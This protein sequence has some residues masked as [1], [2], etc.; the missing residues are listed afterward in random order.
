MAK[1]QY[2]AIFHFDKECGYWVEFPDWEKVNIG[3]TTDGKHYAQA[4]YMAEDLL[5]ML[6]YYQELDRLPFPEASSCE[7][8][9]ERIR[10]NIHDFIQLIDADTKVYAKE[11]EHVK[12]ERRRW[13]TLEKARDRYLYPRM[14]KAPAPVIINTPNIVKEK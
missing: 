3:A 8:Y 2:P 4:L 13:H 5:G 7:A 6:C 1:Y 14:P 9:A 12:K 11:M 10:G